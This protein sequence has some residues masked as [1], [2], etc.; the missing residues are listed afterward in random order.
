MTINRLA[1]VSLLAVISV[2]CGG[3]ITE[4]PSPY[5]TVDIDMTPPDTIMKVEVFNIPLRP[6]GR[7]ASEYFVGLRLG[8]RRYTSVQPVT[9]FRFGHLCALAWTITLNRVEPGAVRPTRLDSEQGSG[10]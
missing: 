6:D 8:A 4:P 9:T 3:E 2:S 1:M 7:L 5:L 10:C